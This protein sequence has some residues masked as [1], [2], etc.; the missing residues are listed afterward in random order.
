MNKQSFP[1]VPQ[2]KL[3]LFHRDVLELSTG[4]L[5]KQVFTAVKQVI[6]WQM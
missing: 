4:P 3:R 5:K 2:N 1:Q 6:H